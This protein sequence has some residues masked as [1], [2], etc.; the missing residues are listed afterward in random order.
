MDDLSAF[1]PASFD[2]VIHPVSTC[3]VPDVSVVYRQVARVIVPAGIYVS[4]H[5]Q[6][7][8]M[9]ASSEPSSHGYE[10]VEPYDRQRTVAEVVGSLHREAGTMEFL[11]RWQE[12]LGGMCRAGFVIEDVIEPDACRPPSRDRQLRPSQPLRRRRTCASRRAGAAI[13]RPP[14]RQRVWTP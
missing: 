2:I 1:S 12:L 11:H 10:L 14:T 8:S 9:Q 6:P 13:C 5:K 4:Q 7:V 3:Y